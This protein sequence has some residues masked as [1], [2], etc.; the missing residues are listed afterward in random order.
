MIRKLGYYCLVVMMIICVIRLTYKDQTL[1]T[2]DINDFTPTLETA[3]TT[4]I[5]PT[6]PIAAIEPTTINNISTDYA[7]SNNNIN[8]DSNVALAEETQ[9]SEI[10]EENC[11]STSDIKLTKETSLED[12]K[13]QG[14]RF[15][16]KADYNPNIYSEL[17]KQYKNSLEADFDNNGLV[18]KAV[19][20]VKDNPEAFEGIE[21]G[22]FIALTQKQGTP[23]I[24]FMEVGQ[25]LVYNGIILQKPEVLDLGD[26]G[27]IE[28]QSPALEISYYE[29]CGGQIMYWDKEQRRF[30]SIS[31]GC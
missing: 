27:N 31:S 26:C 28:L 13:A 7:D 24:F 19:F 23:K 21:H 12:L 4:S 22:M 15:P 3:S 2:K 17:K 20:M 25:G 29:S 5:E 30:L 8:T 16:K 9:V 1:P 10:P 18:D 14:W 6:Y 11:V